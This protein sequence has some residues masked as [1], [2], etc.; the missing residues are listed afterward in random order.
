MKTEVGQSMRRVLDN[1]G[2]KW[3][4]FTP[5]CYDR[6]MIKARFQGNWIYFE[7]GQIGFTDGV[8]VGV[9]KREG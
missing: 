9:R 1:L 6:K 5:G 4:W 7:V 2:K 8:D 3:R